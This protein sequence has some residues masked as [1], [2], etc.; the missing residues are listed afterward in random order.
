VYIF[1]VLL[2]Q[3]CQNLR[4]KIVYTKIQYFEIKKSK[5]FEGESTSFGEAWCLDSMAVRPLA[6]GVPH[7]KIDSAFTD[8]VK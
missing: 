3:K 4:R 7:F 1:A 6:F 8:L 2:Q 5:F